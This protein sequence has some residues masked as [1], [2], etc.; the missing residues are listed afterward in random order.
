[1]LKSLW[2][3]FQEKLFPFESTNTLFNMYKDVDFRFDALN[4]NYIRR[5][6]LENYVNLYSKKPKIL[7]I[8]EAPGKYGCR[9][10]GIPFTSEEQICFDDF[11]LNGNQTSK[12]KKPYKEATATIFWS[13]M[14]EYFPKFFIWNCVPFHPHN[15]NQFDNRTPSK[16]E[17]KEFVNF[18]NEL[19]D[20]LRP[21]EVIAIGRRAECS[22]K[23]LEISSI[24][25][26]HPSHGGKDLF[27]LGVKDIFR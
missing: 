24:C 20:I 2:D 6:N 5:G 27:S 8:G 10:S 9:F 14:K 21:K 18:L 23:E 7:F 13:I 26:R 4:A 3:L 17:I 1:M 16:S 19:I 15:E 12:R 11:C 22:L 25:L